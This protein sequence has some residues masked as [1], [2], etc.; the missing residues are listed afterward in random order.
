[1]ASTVGEGTQEPDLPSHAPGKGGEVINKGAQ[2]AVPAMA[3]PRVTFPW[4]QSPS[5]G[6]G[7]GCGGLY[8]LPA[9]TR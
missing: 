6:V 1:M 5:A 9:G 4:S 8:G 2:V 7:G 3:R